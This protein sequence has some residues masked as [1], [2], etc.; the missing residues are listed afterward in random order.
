MSGIILPP[1]YKDDRPKTASFTQWQFKM[2]GKNYTFTSI[3]PDG[4]E[5][6][7]VEEKLNA[8]SIEMADMMNLI[9][10]SFRALALDIK[11]SG[12]DPVNFKKLAALVNLS[13]SD[14]EGTQHPIIKDL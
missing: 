10:M 11:A 14:A 4:F 5:K 9:M 8:H 3:N 13:V 12:H 7:S 2:D 6:L 1:N